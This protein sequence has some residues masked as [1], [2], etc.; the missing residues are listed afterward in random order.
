MRWNLVL[1]AAVCAVALGVRLHAL[2]R[3]APEEVGA[4]TEN[5]CVAA[6][7]AGGRGWADAFAAGTGP[8]AHVA[9]LYPLLLA[10]VYRLCGTYQTATGRLA[11][12]AL[13][14]AAS[15]L[16]VLLLP[17][18]ARRLELSA[19]AGWAAALVAA[20]L[21]ANLCHEV[22][23]SHEQVLAT[24]ALFGLVAACACL[25]REN[26]SGRRAVR[27]AGA[28]VAVTVLLAPNLLL[29]PGLFFL[30]E[31]WW[32]PGERRRIRRC[33]LTLLAVA[34]VPVAPWLVRNYLVLGGLV[35]LR[36]N[37][38]LELA[39][40]NRPGADGYTYAAGFQALHPFFSAAERDRLTRLGELA[41]MRGK[42]RQALGWI[43]AQPGDFA[44]L[45]LRRVWL[46]WF[47]P[48]ER[49]CSFDLRLRL[50]SRVYGVLG[51]AGLVELLRLLRRGHPAGR[52][53]ACAVLGVG[54]PY[55]V[56]H[57]EMRYRLPVVGLSA[58]LTCSL[59]GATVRAVHARLRP[60]APPPAASRPPL[61]RAA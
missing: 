57:V 52:L 21:P 54:L 36:S 17:R 60:P 37:L 32:R 7:L 34:G 20:R 41:Y 19:A 58:L 59:A 15:T 8:T 23:G 4:G 44:W 53:L 47:T 43:A 42:Q 46:F 31:G 16:V 40:G 51:V 56:T 35:P 22:T 48:D 11:Q 39:A 28:L 26:W 29:V 1:A 55:F 45:T 38:G 10:G 24:L 3:L 14:I 49:W 30:V 13:S 33:G 25:R 50:P 27:V 12:E 9:P 2:W 6:S 18:L 61:A 5:E